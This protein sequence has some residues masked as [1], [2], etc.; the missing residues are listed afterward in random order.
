MVQ[1]PRLPFQLSTRPPSVKTNAYLA[2]PGSVVLSLSPSITSQKK[3]KL[4]REKKN[5]KNHTHIWLA[6]C[7]CSP[8]EKE[9]RRTR[10]SPDCL[11]FPKVWGDFS[12][13]PR[14]AVLWGDALFF[15]RGLEG[16]QR[17]Q[18]LSV[19]WPAPVYHCICSQRCSRYLVSVTAVPIGAMHYHTALSLVKTPLIII[20]TNFVIPFICTRDEV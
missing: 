4:A 10:E 18:A 15:F 2:S 12:R 1:N 3:D 20:R 7:S 19:S 5:K 9:G 16:P 17:S 11:C 6:C 8:K 13:L 14:L